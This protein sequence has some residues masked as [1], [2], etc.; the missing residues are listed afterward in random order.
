MKRDHQHL[1]WKHLTITELALPSTDK[2]ISEVIAR[3]LV[4]M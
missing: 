2:G 4:A 3:G 1:K